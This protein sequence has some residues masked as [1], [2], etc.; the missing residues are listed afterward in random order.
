M[1]PTPPDEDAHRERMTQRIAAIQAD[2]ARTLMR[3]HPGLAGVLAAARNAI[4]FGATVSE[5]TRAPNTPPLACKSGCSWCCY[6]LVSVTPA[7]ALLLAAH[8]RSQPADVQGEL[9]ERLRRL[10]RE[11]RGMSTTVRDSLHLPC[12]FLKEGSCS[13]YDVRP[14][15]CREVTSFDV[16]ACERSYKFGFSTLPALGDG[17]TIL[18]YRAVRIGL[19]TALD[20]AAGPDVTYALELT[21]AVLV[22]LD[23]PDCARRWLAGEDVFSPARWKV[24]EE[25]LRRLPSLHMRWERTPAAGST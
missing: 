14:L 17:P 25:D 6:Q 4:G 1:K 8:V 15:P 5:R 23:T 13:V 22:A 7:E 21:A 2:E 16:S 12:A 10:D 20:E 24:T 9:V 19:W 11:T 18:S 3:Q